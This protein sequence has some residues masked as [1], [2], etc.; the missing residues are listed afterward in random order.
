MNKPVS[1]QTSSSFFPRFIEDGSYYVDKSLLIQD[2][3]ENNRQVVLYTRPRRFGKSLNQT[4]LQAFFDLQT[5]EQYKH[6]F[7]GL[8]IAKNRELCEKHQGKYPVIALSFSG[9]T[10]KEFEDNCQSITRNIYSAFSPFEAIVRKGISKNDKGVEEICEF[11]SQ[12][13]PALTN[14]HILRHLSAFLHQYYGRPCI[15]LLDEYDVPLQSAFLSGYYEKMVDVIRPLMTAALKDNPHI[16]WAILTGC[17]KIAKESIFTG[18]NNPYVN[19]VLTRD[20][21]AERF[22]FTQAEVDALLHAARL[23]DHR[24][25]VKKWYDGYLFGTKEVYNP[26]SV[27]NYVSYTLDAGE[28]MPKAYWANTSGND[29]IRNLLMLSNQD[30]T[31]ERLQT[32]IDGGVITLPITENTVYHDMESNPDTLWSTMLFTGY[33]K[34]AK[35]VPPNSR[36]VPMTLPNYEVRDLIENTILTWLE[37]DYRP[38]A[39]PLMEALL[40]GDAPAAQKQLNLHLQETI[41]CRDFLEYYYHGFLTGLLAAVR[42][43][44]RTLSN[45]EAGDGY[46]DIQVGT[47][48]NSICAILEVK[49]TTD[50]SKLLEQLALAEEQFRTRRYELA[51]MRY[52]T[53]IGYAVVFCRKSCVVKRIPPESD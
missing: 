18:L 42:G 32:L 25:L 34:P 50:E 16:Q 4:M 19:T 37:H 17:L 23:E 33:L 3:V 15:L 28:A 24:E 47:L 49:Q 2:I 30:E 5:A 36:F 39:T 53:I 7:D 43:Q 40:K 20:P 29:I 41:S 27:V 11:L 6:L 10:R 35:P 38:Q 8:A 22:G 9:C 14:L 52:D 13:T 1:I 45:Y 21:S 46:P 48:D 12:D 44:Y 51:R 26:F 31:R